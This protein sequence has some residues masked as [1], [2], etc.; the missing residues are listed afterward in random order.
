MAAG[1]KVTIFKPKI[2]VA[3]TSTV[4]PANSVAYGASWPTGWTDVPNTEE[5]AL[6]TV[7][8]P[9]DD[10][11]SDENNVIAVVPTGES[12]VNISFTS[13]TPEINLLKYLAQFGE[14][15]VTGTFEIQTLTVVGSATG[16]T[17]VV[18]LYDSTGAARAYNVALANS[19]TNSAVATKISTAINADT[20]RQWDAVP[21]S[22][23]VTLTAKYY[24]DAPQATA[25]ITGTGLTSIT[26]A[27]TTPGVA[28][29]RRNYVDPLGKTFM[30]GV[31][32]TYG[33]DSLFA[34]GGMVRAFGY[35]VQQTED[36]EMAFRRTGEDSVLKL[37]ANVRCLKTV[38][39]SNQIAST[40]ITSTDDRFDMFSI[41][42]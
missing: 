19:D 18:T 28:G 1:S 13:I 4:L 33:N 10:I 24:Q 42:G 16:G 26:G 34:F 11:S 5:G 12:A 36:V 29:Y 22:G 40:G 32:G 39:S 6:V 27:T 2:K 38:V 17:T 41:P 30:I 25:T 8:N 37:A 3:P 23:V 20:G 31:E 35:E 7:T 21:S 14:Q 9:M 15:I